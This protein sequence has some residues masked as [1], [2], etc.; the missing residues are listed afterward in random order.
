[1]PG[2]HFHFDYLS[3]YAYL[4]WRTVVPALEGDGVTV[5]PV[6]TLFPALLG[7]HGQLGPAE[8]PPKRVFTFK[9]ALRRAARAGMPLSP[10]AKH[11]FNP[12]LMLRLSGR[13]VAGGHQRRVIDALYAATWADS[14][15]V[16]DE[17]VIATALNDAGL[18]AAALI[19]RAKTDAA[20]AELRAAT[21]AAIAA[22]VFG[23][24]TVRIADE[25]F[26][27]SDQLDFIRD[28]LRGRDAAAD[29]RM[30]AL[31]TRAPDMERPRK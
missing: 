8:I 21:D 3:P 9:D 10:P 6:P 13:G 12:L 11:P 24:P 20:K 25:V 31:V 27:G 23:V 28:F 4:A 18:D 22:G 15:D 14:L 2:A 29:P 17:A 16:T 30:R 1:M 19:S 26:W 7:H 5:D